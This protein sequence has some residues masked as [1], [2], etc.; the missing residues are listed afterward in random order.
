MQYNMDILASGSKI[1]LFLNEILKYKLSHDR[2]Y[3][4]LFPPTK[5]DAYSGN[6]TNTLCR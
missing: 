4:L 1:K 5:I 3:R 6:S 2:E